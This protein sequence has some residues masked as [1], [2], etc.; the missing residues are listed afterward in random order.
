M[1]LASHSPR[2]QKL[3]DELG[4]EFR[5]LT[6]ET[7]ESVDPSLTPI[8]AAEILARRKA[9]ALVDEA[10]REELVIAG[11]TLIDFEGQIIGKPASEQNALEILMLLSGKTHAVHT[12]VAVMRN[13]NVFSGV[14]TAYVTFRNFDEKEA[15]DY[16]ET[17][18]P[19]DKAGAY[20]IQGCGSFLVRK[21]N[22]AYDTVVGLPCKLV[23]ELI[24]KAEE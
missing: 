14:D 6:K 22:G 10:E 18:E 3:L 24:E 17:G 20:G 19:M 1:I 2:R 11:D 13:G 16:I 9:E 15:L 5:V 7:D 23:E 12:G 4:Y 21:V 8:E